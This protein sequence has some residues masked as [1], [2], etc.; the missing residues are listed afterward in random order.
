MPLH[1]FTYNLPS[2]G[3]SVSWEDVIDVQPVQGG[4]FRQRLDSLTTTAYVTLIWVLSLDEYENLIE[5]YEVELKNGSLPFLIDLIVDAAE[6][7][8]V[9]ALFMPE[10]LKLDGLVGDQYQ[11]SAQLEVNP[12]AYDAEYYEA[13]LMLFEEYGND[14]YLISYILD[15]LEK[16]VNVDLPEYS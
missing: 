12:I 11:V 15:L 1:K 7:T 10:M 16:L 9:Q 3:Y 13:I 6:L 8:E 5:T 4:S 2:D 14:P